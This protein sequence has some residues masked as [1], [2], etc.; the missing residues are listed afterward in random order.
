MATFQVFVVGPADATPTGMQALAEAMQQRYGL[1]AADLV[2]R[3]TSGRFRV[4][5]GLDRTTAE[6]YMRELQK[7]GA[8]T[9]MEE[10]RATQETTP[11]PRAPPPRTSSPSLPPQ[12]SR[13]TTSPAF[14]SGLAAAFSG[15]IQASSLGALDHADLSLASIDGSDANLGAPVVRD[16]DQ[17]AASFGPPVAKSVTVPPPIRAST[18]AAASLFAPPEVERDDA[19]LELHADEV[20]DRARRRTSLPP[21]TVPLE[22]AAAATTPP[23]TAKQPTAA[24]PVFVRGAST[25]PPRW[26]LPAGVAI[27]IVLG[28]IPAHFIGGMREHAKYGP[29]DRDLAAAQSAALT[30]AD[31]DDLDG[32]RRGALQRKRDA[33]TLIILT[34]MLVWAAAGGALGYVWFRKI[35]WDDRA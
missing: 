20:A 15:E 1:N 24:T 3:M 19:K 30:Q 35:P 27:A 16:E 33:R 6:V 32:L 25:S 11:V 14:A 26:R 7:I 21:T 31:H 23:L 29:I 10:A 18:P 22:R 4:K 17:L 28:F 9:S 12:P 13:T 34:S 5:A 8:I 2:A